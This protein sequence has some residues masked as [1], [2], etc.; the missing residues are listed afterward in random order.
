[1]EDRH[2]LT[3]GASPCAPSES[4][5]PDAHAQPPGKKIW[6]APEVWAKELRY[7][8]ARR[9][10]AFGEDAGQVSDD[11]VGLAH[12]GGGL[13]SA[14]FT[15]GL[16]QAFRKFRLLPYIDY[17]SAIS[18]GG[19]TAGYLTR[20]CHD[21]PNYHQQNADAAVA[22]GRP[23]LARSPGS[24][25]KD[26]HVKY[27]NCGDYLRRPAEFLAEYIFCTALVLA[28]F[29]SGLM[30]IALAIAIFWRTFDFNQVRDR[31]GVVG[32]NVELFT[33]FIPCLGLLFLWAALEA[34]CRL[35]AVWSAWSGKNAARPRLRYACCTAAILVATIAL[36]LTLTMDLGGW[37]AWA[38]ALA[39]LNAFGVAF[40]VVAASRP[41]SR[42]FSWLKKYN[43]RVGP[44][45]LAVI[46]G[47]CAAP[48]AVSFF[49]H[50]EL[51][52]A[53]PIHYAHESGRY[54]L[55]ETSFTRFVVGLAAASFLATAVAL[56]LAR[57]T[58]LVF[59][60][61]LFSPLIGLIILIANGS[62]NVGWI[63]Q[64]FG[65]STDISSQ[66]YLREPLVLFVTLCVFVLFRYKR[67]LQSARPQ[68][69]FFDRVVFNTVVSGIAIGVPV[70][71]V[72][73]MGR[74]GISGYAAFRD[75]D[76]AATDI[77]DW[78]AFEDLWRDKRLAPKAKA[79][80][81][82][83]KLTADRLND[84]TCLM[85]HAREVTEDLFDKQ[86]WGRN[87]HG[88]FDPNYGWLA[89]AGLLIQDE[90]SPLRSGGINGQNL[91]HR[92]LNAVA[93]QRDAQK[94]FCESISNEWLASK[95]LADKLAEEI[96][97]RA[98]GKL[99]GNDSNERP[100]C[101]EQL[102]EMAE[103]MIE[104]K[105]LSSYYN[106]ATDH[107]KSQSAGQGANAAHLSFELNG[108]YWD[109]YNRKSFN[110]LLLEALYPTIFKARTLVSTPVVV[111]EDQIM[112]VRNL[113]LVGLP[114]L[115]L[116]Y[117]LPVNW[118][119]PFHNFYR[120]KLESE[121][122]AST[123]QAGSHAG[124]GSP[125]GVAAPVPMAH[126]RSH[127]HGGP[128][129]LFMA[130]LHFAR[131][132]KA[133]DRHAE[134][135]SLR[136]RCVSLLMSPK[137]CGT[138]EYG[139]LRTSRYPWRDFGLGEAVA[140]SGAALCPLAFS[141]GPIY[142]I[143]SAFNLRTGKWI[144]RPDAAR[145][146]DGLLRYVRPCDIYREFFQQLDEPEETH[147]QQ[148][149]SKF[150]AAADGGFCD[151]LGIE[152]LLERRCRLIIVTDAGCNQGEEE[153]QA[154]GDVVRRIRLEQNIEILDWDD[155]RPLDVDRMRRDEKTRLSPQHFIMGRI[156]YPEPN[157][158]DG[159]I[160]YIQM[161]MTGDEGI[162]LLQHHR[163][164][165][166]FPGE[167]T[168]NQF[169]SP[170]EVDLFRTLGFHTAEALCEELPPATAPAIPSKNVA[171]FLI[172]RFGDAYALAASA[173]SKIDDSDF[174]SRRP[175]FP[176][177]KPKFESG[178]EPRLRKLLP[179]LDDACT[180]SFVE[181]EAR[182]VRRLEKS[183][184]YRR[185]LVSEVE[186][187]LEGRDAKGS[188]RRRNT[189]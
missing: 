26:D 162:D 189:K 103:P 121:F 25:S 48:F 39:A 88:M 159:V 74:E 60:A 109:P 123:P 161:A 141:T 168:T 152:P 105:R 85:A 126:L 151:Y 32:W 77:L 9:K 76:L 171:E 68:A 81:T 11:L 119:S 140:I 138:R 13:R 28:L 172:Q 20:A 112:R 101:D 113:A 12:S 27:Q 57:L 146:K 29:A 58:R 170:S 86:S 54:V 125:P 5:A 176:E 34:A 46:C 91:A 23:R 69:G 55:N 181:K 187:I 63:G 173:E 64:L 134:E 49:D 114:F 116:F 102:A 78:R 41:L 52:A 30:A 4:A 120:R 3:D 132:Q 59:L 160:V 98:L 184:E 61:A 110:R 40:L 47:I 87:R 131:E 15:L 6:S 115:A 128:Y 94:A 31:L 180:L 169:F 93:M 79:N 130:A 156:I 42:W 16:L 56:G 158:R 122:L 38:P 89:R 62:L 72:G 136:G 10:A 164:H 129:P 95:E 185:G 175:F 24:L 133:D 178:Y 157:V 118:L 124:A 96:R 44:W 188:A 104:G 99:G 97:F 75:P 108:T 7:I 19:Y 70:M 166:T 127:E 111:E 117:L 139:Y 183:A 149:P 80:T 154:L 150:G 50:W 182:C 71:M 67:L 65:I 186:A 51:P 90:L 14:T 84:V 107:L 2:G 66:Q 18:G 135:N 137:F 92:Y 106:Q 143:L 73:W 1:M 144:P 179:A 83:A 148:A 17:L 22:P 21:T 82:A 53:S 45:V 174:T 33:A 147:E 36:S 8:R 177:P 155:D 167:P 163:S 100:D 37:V 145:R 142:W 43:S 35:D 153:F 165:A